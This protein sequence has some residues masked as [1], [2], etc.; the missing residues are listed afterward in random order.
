[1]RNIKT[2]RLMR[3]GAGGRKLNRPG[4]P[5]ILVSAFIMILHTVITFMNLKF[6]SN[7]DFFEIAL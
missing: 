7:Y 6:C 3:E 4:K 5:I 2:I 1:M